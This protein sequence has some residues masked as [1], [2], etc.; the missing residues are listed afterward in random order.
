MPRSGQ[1]GCQ[2][3]GSHPDSVAGTGE[4]EGSEAPF[5]LAERD[6]LPPGQGRAWPSPQRMG[7]CSPLACGVQPSPTART[8]CSGPALDSP[9]LPVRGWRVQAGRAA[10]PALGSLVCSLIVQ[11]WRDTASAPWGAEGARAEGG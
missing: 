8:P 4:D 10:A 11:R 2:H 1:L 5:S 3:L 9:C 7:A 6:P